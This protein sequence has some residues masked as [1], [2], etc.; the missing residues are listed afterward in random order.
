LTDAA[1]VFADM[2]K[3]FHFNIPFIAFFL[4][5]PDGEEQQVSAGYHP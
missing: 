4:F 5:L 2:E 1:A 3:S